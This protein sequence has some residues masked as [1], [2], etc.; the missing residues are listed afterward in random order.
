[1]SEEATT[2]LS[3]Q[4]Y[5][6]KVGDKEGRT[7]VNTARATAFLAKTFPEEAG[8]VISV[9]RSADVRHGMWDEEEEDGSN[10]NCVDKFQHL[11]EETDDF[12]MFD[13]TFAFDLI[14]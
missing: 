7:L 13:C 9:S 11:F 12:L 5:T 6:A 1:M 10:V 4:D 3:F 2:T 14:A 8:A